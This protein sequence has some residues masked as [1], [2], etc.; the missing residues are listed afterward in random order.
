MFFQ[1]QLLNQPDQRMAVLLAFV[2]YHMRMRC[3]QNQIDNF[4]MTL[5]HLRECLDHNLDRFIMREQVERQ[6]NFFA[7]ESEGSS[8]IV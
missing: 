4:R 5:D 7:V 6:K 3:S 2:P 1:L 8:R